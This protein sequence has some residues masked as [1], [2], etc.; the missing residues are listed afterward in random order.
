MLVN[1]FKDVGFI[2]KGCGVRYFHPLATHFPEKSLIQVI[3]LDIYS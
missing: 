3:V 1:D 2:Y